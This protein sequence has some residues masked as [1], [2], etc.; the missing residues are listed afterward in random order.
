MTVNAER[1]KKLLEYKGQPQIKQL[2]LNLS[3][4]RLKRLYRVD[5]ESL[6]KC[7]EDLNL[8]IEKFAAVIEPDYLWIMSL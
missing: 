7:V 5:P 1:A 3:L 4:A 8:V 2:A 6:D